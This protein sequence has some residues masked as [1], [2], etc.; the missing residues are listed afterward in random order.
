MRFRPG[1]GGQGGGSE[2]R[3]GPG[4]RGD[5]SGQ[6]EPE[7]GL[8]GG[9]GSARVSW[10]LR[11]VTGD[12][13]VVPGLGLN[14]RQTLLTQSSLSLLPIAQMGK[15]RLEK[16]SSELTTNPEISGSKVPST[17]PN[18]NAHSL[19]AEPRPCSPSPG[20][21]WPWVVAPRA[22]SPPGGS[23]WLSPACQPQCHLP[24][25]PRLVPCAGREV[26]GVMRARN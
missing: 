18:L 21:S 10:V 12:G 8:C 3:A 14:A 5:G 24:P 9:S 19:E 22:S 25:Q 7:P 2:D 16:C 6:Q 15:L 1:L 26:W 23:A 4:G 11:Q 20:G 13:Q 17:P